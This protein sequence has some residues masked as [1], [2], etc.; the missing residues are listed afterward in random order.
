MRGRPS[1]AAGHAPSADGASPPWRP[2]CSLW[3]KR[4][5]VTE[6]FSREKVIS[7]VRR[8]CQGR[9]VDDDALNL[10]A[11]QV[12]DTVRAAGSPEV[13]SHEVGLAHPRP[14]A[15]SRRGGLPAVR[16]GVPLLVVRGRFRARDQGAARTPQGD[17]TELT[18]PARPIVGALGSVSCPP[19]CI[20]ISSP[21][22]RSWV[23]GPARARASTDDPALRV[24]RRSRLL[25]CRQAVSGVCAENQGAGRRQAVARRD[26]IPSRAAARSRRTRCWPTRAAS[27][28]SRWA[29]IR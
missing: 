28:K 13:P 24:S 19:T 17:N 7:G 20:P 15:R 3:S 2:R 4:S 29:R 22:R 5:G 9:Q 11:Q 27:P 10:L 1:G 21:W 12:E 16:L 18:A 25:T 26:R 23:P 8:A 14:A 6:P